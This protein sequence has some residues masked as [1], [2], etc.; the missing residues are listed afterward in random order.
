MGRYV[1]DSAAQQHAS[2][3]NQRNKSGLIY[4]ASIVISTVG[5]SY[6]AVP[7]Y[8]LYCQATGYGGTTKQTDAGEEI[9]NMKVVDDRMLTIRFEA[10]TS[11]TLQWKFQP[12]QRE[13]TVFPGDTALAFYKAE[14]LTEKPIIG[15]ST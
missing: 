11:R 8:R 9:E 6:A 4:L 15:I 14:N 12:Q 10:G 3:V 5:M 2:Y 7:L 1:T 13:V